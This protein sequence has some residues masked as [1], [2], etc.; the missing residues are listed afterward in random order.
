MATPT[1][2]AAAARQAA[3]GFTLRAQPSAPCRAL[4]D[5]HH[6][7]GHE[8]GHG[9]ALLWRYHR[10]WEVEAIQDELKTHLRQGRRVL[11]RK[12]AELV[13]GTRIAVWS[14]LT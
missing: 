2:K 8:L 11:S 9:C 4:K 1:G 14:R 5:L 7:L 12:T 3:T 6:F 10:R 13:L